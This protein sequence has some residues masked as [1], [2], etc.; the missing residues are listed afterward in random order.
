[1][2]LFFTAAQL[3]GYICMHWLFAFFVNWLTYRRRT[4]FFPPF[5]WYANDHFAV[6]VNIDR[7]MNNMLCKQSDLFVVS[8]WAWFYGHFLA[9]WNECK[10]LNGTQ[11]KNERNWGKNA[12]RN[13]E[14]SFGTQ[15][16]VLW[17]ISLWCDAG[18]PSK[19]IHSNEVCQ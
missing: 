17:W 16:S 2:N 15:L 13:Y 14:I 3:N 4:S 18:S 5:F 6:S 7:L 10:Y 11:W 1:M 9:M 19:V 8:S 12:V